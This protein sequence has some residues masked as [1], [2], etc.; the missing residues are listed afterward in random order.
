MRKR[1]SSVMI[2]S[3]VGACFGRLAQKVRRRIERKLRDPASNTSPEPPSP[4]ESPA[5]EPCPAATAGREVVGLDPPE[6][7]AGAAPPGEDVPVKPDTPPALHIGPPGPTESILLRLPGE[8]RMLIWNHLLDDADEQWAFLQELA[9]LGSGTGSGL[10]S[11]PGHLRFLLGCRQIYHD[12]WRLAWRRV[13]FHLHSRTEAEEDMSMHSILAQR[14]AGLSREKRR[15]V[16]RLSVSTLLFAREETRRQRH[17]QRFSPR[18]VG[19]RNCSSLAIWKMKEK[20]CRPQDGYW[21]AKQAQR[22]AMSMTPRNC[23]LKIYLVWSFVQE[24]ESGKLDHFGEHAFS[25]AI[26]KAMHS[27]TLYGGLRDRVPKDKFVDW[28]RNT[29]TVEYQLHPRGNKRLVKN[30]R[31]Q[32][33][34]VKDAVRLEM[35]PA[36]KTAPLR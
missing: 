8:L 15:A 1:G 14:A 29:R 23:N 27:T 30:V 18:A 12:A 5:G 26:R 16:H 34:A 33:L 11:A 4:A 10:N 19:M 25:H 3:D 36:L 7:S 2:W 21:F 20:P 22:F 17:C 28:D 35:L 31:V 24:E 13:T 6:Q 32:V 9:S